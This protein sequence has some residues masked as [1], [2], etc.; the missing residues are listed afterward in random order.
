M[1]TCRRGFTLIELVAVLGVSTVLF[2]V[3]TGLLIMLM[4]AD[5]GWREQVRGH[6]TVARLADQFRRDV[7]AARR[8]KPLPAAPG[9]AGPGWQLETAPGRVVEYR[10]SPGRLIRVQLAD[11]K[12]VRQEDFSLPGEA[13]FGVQPAD[14]TAG[15][16]G[17]QVAT[18]RKPADP[19][20]RGPLEFTAA[21]GW[22]YR[23]SRQEG[24]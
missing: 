9:N 20:A 16:V 12:T 11:G 1:K 10:A 7:H 17:L 21:L 8:L 18:S 5:R 19:A 6:A 15:L 14:A 13:R 23:F 3:A 22:D 2:G 4:Q 24:P